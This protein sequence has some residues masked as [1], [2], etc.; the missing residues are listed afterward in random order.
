MF[1]NFQVFQLVRV[2]TRYLHLWTALGSSWAHWMFGCCVPYCFLACLQVMR[3][4]CFC[5]MA[6]QRCDVGQQAL[7]KLWFS[8]SS[9][10]RFRW[11]VGGE[12]EI[13]FRNVEHR[14]ACWATCGRSFH[15]GM[16]AT[17]LQLYPWVQLAISVQVFSR[18]CQCCFQV[19][20]SCQ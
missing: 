6:H 15:R 5:V 9:Q 19:E 12:R 18:V 10:A 17:I 20:G 13:V 8:S 11:L 2:A 1:V 14:R 4:L 3:K 7:E 16:V